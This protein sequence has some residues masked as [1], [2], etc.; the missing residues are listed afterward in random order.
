MA[1][2][3]TTPDSFSGDGLLD[4]HEAVRRG[5]AAVADGAAIVDV[6][7]ESTRPG[8]EPVKAEEEIRRVLPVIE[9]LVDSC[10]ALVSID[11]LKASVAARA[12]GAGARI[13]N[14]VSGLQDLDLASVAALHD[15]WLVVTHNRW[16]APPSH[17][18][19]GGYYARSGER[20][21]VEEV[22][23]AL[24]AMAARA[25][26]AG[27]SPE[28][29][30]VDPG[31]GFG[32]APRESLELLRRVGELRARTAPYAMLVGA[33]RKSFVGRVLGL[34]VED[35]LEGSLAAAVAAALAGVEIVRVHDVR[36]SVRG[37]QM[38]S[39]IGLGRDAP[40]VE[41]A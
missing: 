2:V 5:L 30:I 14:D 33:S 39:A 21:V 27:V 18:Q 28:R 4:A 8:A 1:I 22:V 40:L 15:A 16:T 24:L 10:G 19:L 36:A 26:A 9:R 31:L 29:V 6:G 25:T 3:N 34:P 35:R 32:K 38:A 23:E 37:V 11:T 17:D 20:D 13:V 7:G 12:L 41:P